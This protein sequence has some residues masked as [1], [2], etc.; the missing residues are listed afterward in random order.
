M[1]KFNGNNFQEQGDV[2]GC[3]NDRGIKLMS[4]IWLQV[5]LC[6]GGRH[7]VAPFCRKKLLIKKGK[8]SVRVWKT[9]SGSGESKSIALSGE[10]WI[11]AK[12]RLS[13]TCLE[14]L[15]AL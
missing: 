14:A 1:E 3:S 5:P 9:L 13:N 10:Q 6:H 2:Q 12:C 7:K 11:T 15:I 8:F 4:A